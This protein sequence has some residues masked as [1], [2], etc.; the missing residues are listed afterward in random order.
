MNDRDN[1]WLLNTAAQL[2]TMFLALKNHSSLAHHEIILTVTRVFLRSATLISFDW[3]LSTLN[4][5]WFSEVFF[6]CVSLAARTRNFSFLNSNVHSVYWEAKQS[7]T[8]VSFSIIVS[9]SRMSSNM[10]SDTLSR[11]IWNSI[12]DDKL[13]LIKY[14]INSMKKTF[15]MT[16]RLS[17][18]SSWYSYATNSSVEWRANMCSWILLRS[19]ALTVVALIQQLQ[20]FSILILSMTV[21]KE[22]L[23]WSWI[24]W[25]SSLMWALWWTKSST[26]LW[27]CVSDTSDCW[28]SSRSSLYLWTCYYTEASIKE[29]EWLTL[30]D[31][32]SSR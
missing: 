31:C 9:W 22:V 30:R 21:L 27:I 29:I 11:R 26:R 25:I 24:R 32:S 28:K 18:E 4:T 3:V 6:A 10:L 8:A 5:W 1:I 16:K 23:K 17:I 14:K 12:K 15:L 20:E 19:T 7:W 2:F 13:F